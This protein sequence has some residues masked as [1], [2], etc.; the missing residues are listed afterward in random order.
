MFE[1]QTLAGVLEVFC[2]ADHA[3]GLGTPIWNGGVGAHLIKHESA[4][5]SAVA[6]GSG[7]PEN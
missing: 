2:D 6:L 5:Q 4:V 1:P 7:A 3:G